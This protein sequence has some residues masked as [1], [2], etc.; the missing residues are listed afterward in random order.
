MAVAYRVVAY[1]VGISFRP[2]QTEKKRSQALT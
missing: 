1:R 2:S